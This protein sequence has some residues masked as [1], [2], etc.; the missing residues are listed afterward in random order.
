[1]VYFEHA[2]RRYFVIPEW[3]SISVPRS[4][5]NRTRL[6]SK[7]RMRLFP[8][9]NGQT[10]N[11]R[12]IPRRFRRSVT[13]LRRWNR[14]QGTGNREQTTTARE[15]DEPGTRTARRRR[16]EVLNSAPKFIDNPSGQHPSQPTPQGRRAHNARHGYPEQRSTGSPSKSS[17]W[18][19]KAT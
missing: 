6:S 13:E 14:E 2:G 9:L 7:P 12:G 10:R 4:A 8:Q 18:R 16:R 5:P 11:L 15:N 19:A 1:M 17:N 3:K